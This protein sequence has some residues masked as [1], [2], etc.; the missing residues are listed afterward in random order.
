MP[1]EL[2]ICWGDDSRALPAPPS[3]RPRARR[4][5]RVLLCRLRLLGRRERATEEW[6]KETK[7]CNREVSRKVARCEGLFASFSPL[8]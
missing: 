2:V 4:L 8:V 6:Q 3:A 5:R 1:M 7:N